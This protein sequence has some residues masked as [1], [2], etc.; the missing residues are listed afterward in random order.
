MPRPLPVLSQSDYLIQVVDINSHISNC[1]QWR[2]GCLVVSALDFQVGYR[3]LLILDVPWV[4]YKVDR[5]VLGD[6]QRHQVCMG[7]P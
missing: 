6:R 3:G 1:L 4:E 5:A 7:D 2:A